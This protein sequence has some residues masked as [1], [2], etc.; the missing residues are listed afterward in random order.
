MFLEETLA[1][2]KDRHGYL[3]KVVVTHMNSPW[4]SKIRRE[5]GPVASRL[6][7]ALSVSWSEMTVRI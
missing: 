4:E 2:F 1:A 5:L 3:P 6:G 7:V